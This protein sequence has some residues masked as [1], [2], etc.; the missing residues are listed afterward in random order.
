VISDK[1]TAL[2][3]RLD[4]V[5]RK[6]LQAELAELDIQAGWDDQKKELL[7]H[8]ALFG[9]TDSVSGCPGASVRALAECSLMPSNAS[10]RLTK[11]FQPAGASRYVDS[12]PVAY[13]GICERP[14]YAP[15]LLQPVF[16]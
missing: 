8:D 9:Q 11:S 16:I 13:P 6:F 10:F 3:K 15:S 2:I 7:G 12:I 1:K 5:D 14:R 4:N